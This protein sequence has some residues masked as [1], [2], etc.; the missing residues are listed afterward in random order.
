MFK[1]TKIRQI[2]A[3]D[4]AGENNTNIALALSVSRKS[5]VEIKK[6]VKEI[7]YFPITMKFPLRKTIFVK[8]LGKKRRKFFQKV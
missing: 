2:L 3:L 7:D 4:Y 8:Y 1:K 6:K 5:I